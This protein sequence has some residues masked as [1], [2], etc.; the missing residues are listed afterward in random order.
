MPAFDDY[1][2]TLDNGQVSRAQYKGQRPVGRLGVG[3]EHE[4]VNVIVL[5]PVRLADVFAMLADEELVQLKVFA[6]NGFAYS[7]HLIG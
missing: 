7:R 1:D 3:I 2:R 5:L 4:E 6:D